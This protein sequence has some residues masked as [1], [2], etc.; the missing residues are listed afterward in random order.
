MAT[1]IYAATGDAL[2]VIRKQPRGWDTRLELVGRPTQCVA[3]DP[4]RPER[5][6][7]GTFGEGLWT[8][9]DAGATW[10]PVGE[11]IS[12]PE[13]MAVAVSRTERVNGQ[14]VVW[15]GTEPSK[16]F[17]SEDV[18]R[19]WVERPTLPQ[20]PSAPTWSFPPRPGTH[21]V[22][23]IEPDPNVPER[24]FIG[25]EL[26][27]VMRSLD[28][29]L[30]W[31]DRK[32]NSQYDS[33]TL[34]APH[35][36]PGHL[37]E[38]AGGGFAESR[39]GGATW[40]RDD[41]GLPWHYLWGLAVDPADPA[42]LV[43][44]VSPGARQAHHGREWAESTLCRRVGDGPWQEVRDGLPERRGTFAYVLAAHDAEPH[45]FYAAPHQGE[46]YRSADAGLS[47]EPLYAWPD[48]YG[49]KDVTGMAVVD[50]P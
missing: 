22:R 13:L 19:S 3:V 34:R 40:Q 37:F 42:T 20:L 38:A 29:G 21:H 44:S 5:V 35:L 49:P 6:Y 11:G 39:D 28:G 23:W 30:T 32:P 26:G 25:I 12:H 24:L 1:T 41:N 14:G 27:G 10:M 50:L 18:G 4:F 17:R 48:G 43:V 45:T 15:A 46:L 31:E 33:H 36:A 16:L 2:A 7:C 8:S 9:A 47:W